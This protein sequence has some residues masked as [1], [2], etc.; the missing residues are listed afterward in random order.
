MSKSN[1]VNCFLVGGPKCGTTAMVAHL[2]SHESVFIS[3][4]KECNFFLEDMPE[5]KYA[6]NLKEYHALFGQ[7]KS[8][9]LAYMD[10]SILY[11][12]SEDALK[13][14]YEYNKDAKII[15]MLRDPMEMAYSFHS[16]IS[17]TLDEDIADFEQAW[18][19]E[20]SRRQG[21]NIPKNCRSTRLLFYSEVAKYYEQ[22]Q[23][24]YKYFPEDQVR[25]ILFDDFKTSNLVAYKE[26]LEFIN[27]PYD[28]KIDFPRVNEAKKAKNKLINK[29]VNR[30]PKFLKAIARLILKLVNKPRFGI[31]ERIDKLNRDKDLRQELSMEMK[32]KIQN[33]YTQDVNQLSKLINRDLSHWLN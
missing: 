26:L 24:V 4:P 31:L 8:T 15:A 29:F 25:V 19:L 27:V 6:R 13:A 9:H 17:Y 33:A 12:H 20:Q 11:L 22:L 28:G 5:M 1:K 10:A 23:R 18:D 21:K 2:K 7:F 32:V 3:E 30:P 16:Q 14:I